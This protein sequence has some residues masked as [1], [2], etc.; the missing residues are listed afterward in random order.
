MFNYTVPGKSVQTL[1]LYACLLTGCLLPSQC[2]PV[3][4]YSNTSYGTQTQFSQPRLAPH[5]QDLQPKSYPKPIYS[6][7]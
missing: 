2:S 7:R 5:N 4:L 3:G 1:F 6:Y